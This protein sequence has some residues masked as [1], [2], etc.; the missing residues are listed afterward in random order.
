MS[1]RRR[2]ATTSGFTLM[3]V[4][5]AV[6]ILALGLTAIFSSQGQAIKVGTRA[7]H[8]NIAALMARCKMSELEEQVLK[9]GLPAIDDS[10]RDGCCEGAELEGFEC[11][12]RLD[13]VVLPDDALTEEGLEGEEGEGGEG[14]GPTG[15][16]SDESAQ[17][18]AIDSM[19]G[20][21]GGL[22]GGDGFAEMAIGI[23]FPVLKPAIEE[24]VRRASVVVRWREGTSTRE[25]DVVQYLVAEQPPRVEEPAP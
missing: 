25:F 10:G 9:E 7:Q 14:A 19:L 3:E 6:G 16:L 18:G 12:W 8:M 2:L 21:G 15:I 4:M 20:G 23:A 5:V 22:G 24:Q 11:E 1:A 13:R 17:T